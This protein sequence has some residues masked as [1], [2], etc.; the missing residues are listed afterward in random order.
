MITLLG[1][2]YTTQT[3]KRSVSHKIGTSTIFIIAAFTITM[4]SIGTIERVL[5]V[6][7]GKQVMGDVDVMVFPRVGGDSK[8]AS[9][10]VAIDLNVNPYATVPDEWQLSSS[11]N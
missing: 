6:Y 1:N 3:Q 8:S 7:S 5:Q 11:G 2:V 4:L 10:L 9:D